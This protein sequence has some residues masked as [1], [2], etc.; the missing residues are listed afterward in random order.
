MAAG[1]HPVF[2]IDDNVD[3]RDG[4]SIVLMAEGYAV[5]TAANG[6]EALNKLYRGL[7]PCIILMD[8]M[9]PVMNGFEFRQEQLA[10]PV[11]ASIPLIAYSGVTDPRQTAVQLNAD[12]YI[13]R[14]EQTEH[15]LALVDRY[16][17]KPES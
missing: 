13:H 11:F 4:L 17:L 1:S 6:R 3:I 16:C 7:Q 10:N 14:P 12:A 2:V 8:L 9:M 5:E 15:I